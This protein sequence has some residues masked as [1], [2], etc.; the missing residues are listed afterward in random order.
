M[1]A[2]DQEITP[3]VFADHADPEVQHVVPD[4]LRLIDEGGAPDFELMLFRSLSAGG[5]QLT[6]RFLPVHS[7]GGAPSVPLA[8]RQ[9]IALRTVADDLDVLLDWQTVFADADDAILF[10]HTLTATHASL[11]M[12]L[13][14]EGSALFEIT[15]EEDRAAIRGPQPWRLR[16]ATETVHDALAAL[17][18]HAPVSASDVAIAVAS[19]PRDLLDWEALAAGVEDPD[20]NAA[21]AL[22]AR[23]LGRFFVPAAG[24]RYILGRR[25]TGPLDLRLDREWGEVL[26][27]RLTWG[28]DQ[29]PELVADAGLARHFPMVDQTAPFSNAEINLINQIPLH[30]LSAQKL[31][32][33]L[34]YTGHQ[35]TETHESFVYQP[36][37]D[38]IQSHNI[39]LAGPSHDF[40]MRARARLLLPPSDLQGFP[41]LWPR[42]AAFADRGATLTVGI[43][44]ADL[45]V[46]LRRI[47]VEEAVFDLAQRVAFRFHSADYTAVIFTEAGQ[48]EAWVVLPG[49]SRDYHMTVEAENGAAVHPITPIIGGDPVIVLAE[50]LVPRTPLDVAVTLG[51]DI[52]FALIEWQDQDQTR[53][54]KSTVAT[55]DD[56]PHI[57]FWPVSVFAPLTLRWR[58]SVIRRNPDGTTTPMTQ[59]DWADTDAL[60]FDIL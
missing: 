20:E 10:R 47:E 55:P 25:E 24:G 39:V 36:G 40:R 52:E 51:A 26:R 28:F 29:A 44:P 42:D 45:D 30:P 35:G 41:V 15:L 56:I 16:G 6:A 13:A 17:L 21:A 3:G 34:A 7:A 48:R 33:D 2:L 14:R 46:Q 4:R 12:E 19:L 8:R 11:A 32:V 22:A 50:D 53:P 37:D 38:P 57:Q 1:L 59:G 18:S 9:R 5:G 58:A 43:S 27:T 60:R 54:L 31:H 23:V 49:A